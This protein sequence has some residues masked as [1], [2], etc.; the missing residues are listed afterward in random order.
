MRQF[1]RTAVAW[2]NGMVNQ[3]SKN[4][5]TE[6]AS[7]DKYVLLVGG[8]GYIGTTITE[9]FL[10]AGYRVRVFDRLIYD[11]QT[12]VPM[13][14]NRPGYEFRYGDITD[15]EALIAALDG[16]TDV[17]LLAGLVGDP[18]TKSFPLEAEHINE[19]GYERALSALSGR[20]LNRVIFVSTCSNY[21]LIEDKA[22]ATEEHPL[23]PLSAY[24]KAKVGVEEILLGM[25]E[26]ADFCPT[27]L[28]FATAFGL[29]A[30][31]RF[32]LTVS[33]FTR[34]LYLGNELCVYD[35]DTWRPYCHVRDFA[36][37]M[38]KV[39]TAPAE[40]VAFQV[41]NA[42]GDVNNFTK[43]MLVDLIRTHLPE[44]RIT[45]QEHGSDPRNYRVD[46]SK[47]RNTLDFEPLFTVDD[48]V[49]ELIGAMDQGLFRDISRPSRFF[50]NHEID[51]AIPPAETDIS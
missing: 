1:T 29:S 25:R 44:P 26:M 21:G 27:V 9:Q 36:S 18:I 10:Q 40:R 20:G 16:I 15:T 45:F 7:S 51:Y 30:R 34:D 41:F 35:A 17:V 8:A 31:M 50:G 47:L 19:T 14:L 12:C 13:F 38:Q 39:L 5:V 11:N 42:G 48:G 37:I 49:R 22:L 3:T 24:A 33:E 4:P 23:S 43:R 2:K 46:F 28:R 6:P 32:D